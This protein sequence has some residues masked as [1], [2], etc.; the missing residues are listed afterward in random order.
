MKT[1]KTTI[2]AGVAAALTMSIAIT[3]LADHAYAGNDRFKKVAVQLV[4]YTTA[5]LEL[6][7][8]ARIV[9]DDRNHTGSCRFTEVQ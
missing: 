4:F 6:E 5:N 8:I 2:I 9:G 3:S 1:K 7:L